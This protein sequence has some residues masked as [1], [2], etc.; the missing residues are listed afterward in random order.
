LLSEG[1]V[2]EQQNQSGSLLESKK[3]YPF[4][5]YAIHC[6]IE[7]RERL[8][9]SDFTAK[10]LI[11]HKDKTSIKPLSAEVFFVL[12]INLGF[13][14]NL[15]FRMIIYIIIHCSERKQKSQITEEVLTE[16]CR[17]IK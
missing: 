13:R 9:S 8:K 11:V 5:G 15:G 1:P 4:S 17:V 14:K 10:Q 16:N 6:S 3:A 12:E 2:F 7:N